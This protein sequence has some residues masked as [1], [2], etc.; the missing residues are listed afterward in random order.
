MQEQVMSVMYPGVEDE[1][2][3]FG[4]ACS[5]LYIGNL[6]F[7]LGHNIVFGFTIPRTRVVFIIF[8]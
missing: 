6:V 2:T 3:V 5:M 7:R 8:I 1:P 4:V